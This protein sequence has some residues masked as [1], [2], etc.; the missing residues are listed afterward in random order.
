MYAKFA[1]L[2]ALVATAAAQQ[3]CT[4][5]RETHPSLTWAKC[6]SGGQCS[7]VSGSVTI[8]ANWRWLHTVSGSDNCYSGNLWETGVCDSA[9]SC[10]SQCCVDGAEYGTTYGATTSGNALSL[11][12]V[13]K[14]QYGSN[15]GSRLYLMENESK[16]QSM[17]T[18]AF[19]LLLFFCLLRDRH[20]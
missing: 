14:H 20:D 1:A 17:S 2:S 7:N 11:K 6:T 19:F 5:T 9:T 4:L 13:T 8:D 18:S 3:V 10:A 15:V 16:Y 12:F